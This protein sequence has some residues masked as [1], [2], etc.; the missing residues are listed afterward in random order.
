MKKIIFNILKSKIGWL[1]VIANLSVFL[2]LTEE[3]TQTQKLSTPICEDGK[4]VKMALVGPSVL[5]SIHTLLNVPALLAS[6]GISELIFRQQKKDP[7]VEYSFENYPI[8][9][10]AESAMVIIFEFFQWI[11]IG[12]LI[13]ILFYPRKRQE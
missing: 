9:Y 5:F 4:I 12:Y 7:C 3:I 6:V 8:V 1:L 10:G 13:E 11:V 2:F